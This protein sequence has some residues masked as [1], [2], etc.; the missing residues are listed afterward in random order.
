MTNRVHLNG[1]NLVPHL[2]GQVEKSPRE[3]CL[4]VNDDQQRV[5][6]RYD[7]WKLVFMEQRIQGTL[8]IWAEPFVT[9]RVPKI[10]NLRTD[11]YERARTT[12]GSLVTS[13]CWCP[14]RSSWASS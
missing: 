6:L 3:S 8:R 7:S 1:D 13:S 2:T 10:F 4:Y 14:R 5:G 12:T 11:P 9:L